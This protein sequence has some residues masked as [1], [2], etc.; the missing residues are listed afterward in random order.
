MSKKIKTLIIFN[1]LIFVF[2]MM[3][4]TVFASENI[5]IENNTLK[6]QSVESGVKVSKSSWF[7]VTIP[8][9]IV[10]DGSKK[11]I[12]SQNYEVTVN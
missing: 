5:K 10:L 3:S 8:K 4:K 6:G 2:L 11:D 12:Y 7:K 9:N 1:T